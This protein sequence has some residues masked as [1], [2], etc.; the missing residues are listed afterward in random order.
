MDTDERF[1]EFLNYTIGQKE[2]SLVICEEPELDN[3]VYLLDSEN[4]FGLTSFKGIEAA[5]I[6]G[7]RTYIILS[8]DNAPH[9]YAMASQY[10][11]GQIYLNLLEGG[12]FW[13]DVVHE[14]GAFIILAPKAAL[15]VSAERD[16]VFEKKTGLTFQK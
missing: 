7:N 8:E 6:K 12:E 3:F 11:S 15:Q 16:L 1:R 10:P 2:P 14:D 13:G 9:V 4:F 5:F